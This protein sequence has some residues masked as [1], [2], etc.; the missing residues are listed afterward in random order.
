MRF[1][2][3]LLFSVPQDFRPNFGQFSAK[4]GDSFHYR[5]LTG[6]VERVRIIGI[7]YQTFINGLFVAW[8]AVRENFGVES[9]T[10]FSLGA[11]PGATPPAA[12]HDIER[13]FV[14]YQ[15]IT[16]NVQDVV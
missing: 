6:S 14:Q 1:F 3:N 11:G 10:A 15:M 8:D 7:L 5:N 12:G 9:S 16:I 4:I 2:H 13:A